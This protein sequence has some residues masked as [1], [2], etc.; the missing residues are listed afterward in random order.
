M[1]MGTM[2]TGGTSHDSKIYQNSRGLAGNYNGD[3]GQSS[4]APKGNYITKGVDSSNYYGA[5]PDK[6][7]SN[8]IPLTSDFSK[9]GR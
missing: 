2:G 9:F 1:G 6:G 3:A 8:F 7:S 5:V 4:V